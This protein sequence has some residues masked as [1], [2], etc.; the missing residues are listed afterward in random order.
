M[1]IR[2]MSSLMKTNR[3]KIKLIKQAIEDIENGTLSEGSFLFVV[4][5]IVNE[6]RITEKGLDWA[7]KEI[8]KIK[9][10][11]KNNEN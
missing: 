7:R 4:N 6:E 3:D 1:R 9:S 8:E 2:W 5:N 10:K 11:E